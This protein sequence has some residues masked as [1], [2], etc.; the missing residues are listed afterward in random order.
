L[1]SVF[2]NCNI[3]RV[4]KKETISLVKHVINYESLNTGDVNVIFVGD[5]Y[6]K[7]LNTK[8]L[9]HKWVTDVISFPLGNSTAVEGEVY[10]NLIRAK[11]QAKEYQSTFKNEVQRLVIHGIL[12]LIGYT[13]STTETRKTMSRLE[14]KYLQKIS[15]SRKK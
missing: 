5:K 12:H 6:I 8:F 7:K 9:K 13:D 14:D 15:K 10:V 3:H 4:N 11:R 1:I 2:N